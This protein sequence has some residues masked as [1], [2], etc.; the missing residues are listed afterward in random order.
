MRLAVGTGVEARYRDWRTPLVLTFDDGYR[1]NYTHAFALAQE[2][3]VPIT[4]FLIPSYIERRNHFWWLEGDHLVNHAQVGEATIEGR[5]YHL[6]R[7]EDCKALAQTIDARVRYASSVA[8]REA[9]LTSVRAILQVP[10]SVVPEDDPALPFTWAEVRE[11]NQC[12]WVSF[13]AHTMHHPVL[14]YLTDP[15]E[16]QREVRECR[17]VLEQELGHPV[18]TFAYPLGLLEHIGDYGFRAVQEAGYDW[19][20]TTIEGF[21][22]PQTDPYLLRRIK[23]DIT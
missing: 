21:N 1:D 11:M 16:V 13:G 15:A 22:T 23:I 8:E 9:F 2:L 7:Q 12:E 19:A 18:R 20:V 14:A 6:D 3:Q 4:F 5:I 17:T 10:S